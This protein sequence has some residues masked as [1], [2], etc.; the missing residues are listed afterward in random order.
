MQDK[1]DVGDAAEEDSADCKGSVQSAGKRLGEAIVEGAGLI[2]GVVAAG[3]R[4][5]ARKAG[6]ISESTQLRIRNTLLQKKISGLFGE[7]GE[8][9]F[10]LFAGGAGAQKI[11]GDETV[12]G[13]IESVK[14][15]R[16]EIRANREKVGAGI[17]EDEE[18]EERSQDKEE[19]KEEEGEEE[20]KE[21]EEGEKEAKEEEEDESDEGSGE[22]QRKRRRKRK[23]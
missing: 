9:V 18:E 6:K 7:L 2:A 16:E 4:S 21:E 10:E 13:I 15:C 5:A 8:R 11:A 17:E 12:K 20:T 19:T 14:D 3:A 22:K 23:G 1:E